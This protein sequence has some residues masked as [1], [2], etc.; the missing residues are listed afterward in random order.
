M[1]ISLEENN[2]NL[3][4]AAQF[5]SVHDTCTGIHAKNF[6]QKIETVLKAVTTE[7]ACIKL[8][9]LKYVFWDKDVQNWKARAKYAIHVH[10]FV[11]G[12]NNS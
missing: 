1:R 6:M 9:W 11:D 2:F 3:M 4:P 7:A 10:C 8:K 5:G 12:I